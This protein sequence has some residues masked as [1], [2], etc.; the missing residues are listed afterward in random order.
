MK[1]IDLLK[2]VNPEKIYPLLHVSIALNAQDEKRQH[3]AFMK[4]YKKLIKTADIEEQDYII[5][6]YDGYFYEAPTAKS[7]EAFMF[8]REEI[9]DFHVYNELESFMLE[10]QKRNERIARTN[11][12]D[13][14]K[15]IDETPLPASRY[16]KMM[17]WKDVLGAEIVKS[18]GIVE[19]E[20]VAACIL[21]LMMSYDVNEEK[22]HKSCQKIDDENRHNPMTLG[23]RRKNALARHLYD[24]KVLQ[25]LVH[26]EENGTL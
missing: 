22:S 14:Q 1:V 12:K 25:T 6:I 11:P 24:Y 20:F 18:I 2:K 21:D 3:A 5:L 9:K 16:L 26:R 13:A 4:A 19:D 15:L 23:T 17:P 7:V 8:K 10:D